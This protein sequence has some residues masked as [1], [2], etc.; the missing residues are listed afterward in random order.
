[1]FVPNIE[2]MGRDNESLTIP[3]LLTLAVQ[4]AILGL[5]FVYNVYLLE[6]GH[7]ATGCEDC[8]GME[9]FPTCHVHVYNSVLQSKSST[10]EPT[11]LASQPKSCPSL[12]T[13]RLMLYH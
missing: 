8:W 11:S 5:F 7:L 3:T 4:L 13:S 1:M 2:G 6:E 10:T 12:G 9:D